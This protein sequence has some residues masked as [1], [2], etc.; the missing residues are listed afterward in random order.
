MKRQLLNQI[1]A[2]F[3][4]LPGAVTIAALPSAAMAQPA[5]PELRSVQIASD[6]GLDAGSRL[7]F[8]VTGTPRAQASLR[9][10]GI[11]ERIVLNE[12]SRGVYTGRYTVKRN[13]RI[14]NGDEVRAMLRSGNLTASANYTLSDTMARAPVAVAPPPVALRI[15]RFGAAPID[16]LEPGAELR[17]MLEGAPGANVTVDL[18]GVSNDVALREIRPGHYE[19]AYTLRRSDNLNPTRPVVATLRIGDRVVNANLAQPLVAAAPDTKPP[20]IGALSP[21]EGATVA[22]GPVQITANFDDRGGSGVDPQSVQIVVSGRNVTRESQVNAQSVN[23][24]GMLPPG[25]HTVEVTARDQAGNTVRRNWGFEV[26]AAAP[27]NMPI[28]ILNH[29]NN[30]QVDGRST[31]IE[32]RTN[33]GATVNVKVDAVAQMPGVFNVAQQVHAQT[34]QADANGNFSFTFNSRSPLPGMRYD[35]SIT[36]TNRANQTTEARMALFQRQS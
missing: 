7:T 17:F 16:R 31:V 5:Q 14:D 29:S 21:Q 1:T 34:L 9:I 11:R 20:L 35:I 26:A 36:S 13:D 10:R 24:R 22:G 8:T 32:G 6:G 33:P 23:F 30:G 28:Q 18:P 12:T 3:L 15:E 19:G 25:H 27:A 4:M 2:A